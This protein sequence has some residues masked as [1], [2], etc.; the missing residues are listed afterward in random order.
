[1]E[2]AIENEIDRFSLAIDVI[3]RVPRI[4]T[5]GAHVKE[6][7]RDMQLDCRHYAHRHGVDRAEITDWRWPL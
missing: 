7:L 1:M 2:L 4:S 6:K 3:D 5:T